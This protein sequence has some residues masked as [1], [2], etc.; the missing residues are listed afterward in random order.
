MEIVDR[1]RFWGLALVLM[2]LA[3]C[4]S[5]SFPGG[6]SSGMVTAPGG[7]VAHAGPRQ[8]VD[9]SREAENIRVFLADTRPRA[10]WTPVHLKP[11]GV[12]YVRTEA[13]IDRRDLIGI[14]SATDQSGGGILVLILSDAGFRKMREATAA[15]P[16]LRLALVVGQTMLAA[17][18]YAAPVREHQLAFGVGSARNAE[19]AAH[20]VAGV[21]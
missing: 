14:Q 5:G 18:A 1:L 9:A 6:A 16:G 19:L 2:T 3:G 20:A 15:N 10:G 11:S 7:R 17:P 21:R 4:Q 12:L 8:T 13:I